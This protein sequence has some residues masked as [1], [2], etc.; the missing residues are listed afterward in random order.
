MSATSLTTDS[1]PAAGSGACSRM[2]CDPCKSMAQLNFPILPAAANA[3]QQITAKVGS[4]CWAMSWL[5]SVVNARSSVPQPTPRAYNMVSRSV[6]S[7][8][9]GSLTAP[10]AVGSIAIR[11]SFAGMLR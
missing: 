6:Q 10:T 11:V 7:N 2:D 9:I 1:L 4:T 3:G 8:S 5:L